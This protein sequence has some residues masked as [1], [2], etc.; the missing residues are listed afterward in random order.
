LVLS[1]LTTA[2]SS[3]CVGTPLVTAPPEIAAVDD[4]QATCKIAKDPLNPM[5]IEWPGTSKVDFDIRSQEGLV[6]VS[7]AGCTLKVLPRCNIGGSYAL[8]TVTPTRDSFQMT[9]ATDLYAR[10]P[11]AAATLKGELSSGTGLELDYV[12]V[13]QR[14]A[15]AAPKPGTGECEGA[16]HYVQTITVGAYTLDAKART[17][18]GA[19]VDVAQAGAG[20][21]RAEGER[22]VRGS[23]DVDACS[24]KPE[25]ASCMAIIQ[26]GLA[27]L[28]GAAQ[29]TATTPTAA[30][31]AA[32]PP[33][34]GAP[35]KDDMVHVPA[36]HTFACYGVVGGYCD[37]RVQ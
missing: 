12:A 30:G 2:L 5:V 18:L 4:Q 13:G 28:P 8:K 32:T 14:R 15:E 3:G 29:K 6:A 9:T 17:S 36:G 11:L 23:G 10:L 1:L 27:A 35:V 31:P 21:G 33:T 16:T 26:L 25:G 7:Y 24:S 19:G 22:R 37:R 20:V 34:P